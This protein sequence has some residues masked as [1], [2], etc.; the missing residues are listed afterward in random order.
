[1]GDWRGDCEATQGKAQVISVL[2]CILIADFLTG[3]V[4][5]AEDTYGVPTWPLLGASV[6]EPNIRHHAEPTHFLMGSFVSRNYQ[7]IAFVLL[8]TAIVYLTGWL[9]WQVTL[10]ACITS[11]GNELHAWTHRRPRSRI[12]RLLQDMK[13]IITPEQHAKHHRKPYDTNFCTVTNWLN[14]VLD[15][16]KFWRGLELAIA[17]CGV[18]PARLTEARGGY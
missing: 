6:I 10:V 7:V 9:T 2:V 13:L 14:P 18:H 4:H 1:M 15:T 5:W 17:M 16:C 12:V 3:A 11:M 8:S